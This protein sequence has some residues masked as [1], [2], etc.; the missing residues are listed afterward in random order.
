MWF[1]ISQVSSW[2]AADATVG[3]LLGTTTKADSR[4][5]RNA[6]FIR[7]A[8]NWRWSCRMNPAFRWWREMRPNGRG[9]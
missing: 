3:A 8:G 6:G 4:D 7:Q 9:C 1:G 5:K 2:F